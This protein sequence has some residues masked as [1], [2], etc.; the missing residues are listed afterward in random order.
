MYKCQALAPYFLPFPDVWN[1]KFDIKGAP[2]YFS[3]FN[4]PVI[5]VLG[6]SKAPNKPMLKVTQTASF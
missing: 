2:K 1:W 6:M 3:V 4:S 5:L